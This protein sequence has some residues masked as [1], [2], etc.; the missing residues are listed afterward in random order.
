MG[1]ITYGHP[2]LV[3]AFRREI[4]VVANGYFAAE[5][6]NQ[7]VSDLANTLATGNTDEK[8]SKIN[9][10]VADFPIKDGLATAKVLFI[11]TDRKVITG[12][13]TINLADER[14]NLRLNPSPK[15]ATLIRLATPVNIGGT[16]AKPTAVPNKLA[17]L[18]GAL[19]G[20][21]LLAPLLPTGSGANHPCLKAVSTTKAAPS[22]AAEAA[23]T[24]SGGES[25]SGGVGGF[26]KDLGR[27]I[28]RVLGG[29]GE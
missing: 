6:L 7:M 24:E 27:K 26:F 13:G 29:A 28:D 14:L 17:T 21:G 11:D 23:E 9:C 10:I 25:K 1:T 18:P 20:I 8:G 12:Q 16:L 15:K 19:P 3:Q 5:Y 22:S 2:H 4:T